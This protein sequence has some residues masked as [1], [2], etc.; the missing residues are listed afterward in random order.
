MNRRRLKEHRGFFAGL[1]LLT[2]VAGVGGW[3]L[4]ERVGTAWLAREKLAE[5]EREAQR[6]SPAVETMPGDR[7]SE[8]ARL[9]EELA[10]LQP[11]AEPASPEDVSWPKNRAEAFFALAQFVEDMRERAADSGVAIAA[12]ER[13]GF[14]EHAHTGP[15]LA[16]IAPVFGE[17]L[18]AER[19]LAA[20]FDAK[21]ARFVGLQRPRSRRLV[22]GGAEEMHDDFERGGSVGAGGAE[23]GGPC[24]F[25][26]IFEGRTESLR[27]LLNRLASDASP[28][29]V[30]SVEAQ[31]VAAS[32]PGHASDETGP[33][34]LAPERD[35]RFTVMIE[36]SQAVGGG[37][38]GE[39]VARAPTIEWLAPA[40]QRR[41]A[42]WR[43]E[44][45]APPDVVFDAK[46][47][48]FSVATPTVP[49]AMAAPFVAEARAE[50]FAM[51]LVEIR[52]APFRLQLIGFAG[53][54]GTYRGLFEDLET[55]ETFFAAGERRVPGLDVLIESVA[56]ERVEVPLADS[57]TTHRR[58]ASARV[59]D[60]RT[61]EGVQLS[62]L[63]RR[64]TDEPIAVVRLR[65]TAQCRVV[66]EGE[67][68]QIG[69]DIYRIRRIQPA[70]P[71]LEVSCESSGSADN[72]R[73]TLTAR[74]NEAPAPEPTS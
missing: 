12:D 24:A 69:G 20:L 64:F 10:T 11:T 36:W 66:R 73:R 38:A 7:E 1:A 41:G 30:R 21:P 27:A 2:L 40:A 31:R 23:A 9:S 3:C 35:S 16:E 58:A 22:S 54:E 15:T 68:V 62:S 63:E 5:L 61:G 8:F 28:A 72:E 17:R 13:F 4:H 52:R 70:P 29:V 19:L 18:V 65:D 42:E 53:D 45:F 44:I 49:A 47:E 48:R 71:T 39:T 33:T 26:M 37:K 57:M 60:E 74:R 59:R 14:A 50:A 55:G 43:F 34:C 56:V 46:L 6:Q 67:A 32:E 51:E 25:R